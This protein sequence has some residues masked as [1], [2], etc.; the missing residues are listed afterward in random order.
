V[1]VALAVV[2]VVGGA[3]L[4]MSQTDDLGEAIT[5]VSWWRFVLSVAAGVVGTV[6]VE[7]TWAALLRSWGPRPEPRAAAGMFYVTQLG[8][9]I[10]GSVWPVLAQMQFGAAWGIARSVMFAANILLLGLVTASGIVV[11]ALLL[12]WSSA[13][14]LRD[15]WWL[16][17]LVLPLAIGLHPRVLPAVLNRLLRAI[18]REPLVV[19]PDPRSLGAAVAWAL[20]TWAAMG[21]HVVLLASA[22]SSPSITL[23]AASTG[24]MALAWAAGIAFIPAPAGA[25]VREGIL[26]LTLSPL[27]GTTAAVTVAL[28]SRVGLL[29]VDVL[30]AGWGALARRASS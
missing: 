7:R 18:G 8:K 12:P 5:Q 21:L 19:S 27:I 22:F 2:V 24:G 3:Y 13:S 15:Y 11:G 29:L 30:L 26:T 20:A 17:L 16:V 14:G 1:R 28:G 6:C 4:L 23:L 10:P 25:G 9:Y